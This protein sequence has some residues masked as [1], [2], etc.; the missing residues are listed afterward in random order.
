MKKRAR[1][2]P[3]TPEEPEEPECEGDGSVEFIA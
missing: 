3:E 2:A 1:L